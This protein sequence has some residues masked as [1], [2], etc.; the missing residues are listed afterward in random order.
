MHPEFS[1]YKIYRDRTECHIWREREIN[2]SLA[3]TFMHAY[4]EEKVLEAT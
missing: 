1:I 2:A 4:M 3:T